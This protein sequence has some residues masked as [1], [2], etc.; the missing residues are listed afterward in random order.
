M[1]QKIDGGE[2]YCLPLKIF[3]YKIDQY[4][5]NGGLY[6]SESDQYRS[7]FFSFLV[8]INHKAKA[9]LSIFAM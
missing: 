1:K 9:P 3:L 8:Y 7:N 2:E 4:Q 6:R 5:L